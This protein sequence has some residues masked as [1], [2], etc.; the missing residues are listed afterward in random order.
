MTHILITGGAGFIGGHLARLAL[1]AGHQVRLLDNLSPQIHGPDAQFVAPAGAEF[2]RGDVNCRADVEQAIEGVGCVI[3]LAAETGTGQSMY[4]IERYYQVNVQGTALLLDVLANRSTSVRNIVLA[5]SRS[6]YG[7][8]AYLCHACDHAGKRC[9]PGAREADQLAAHNWNPKCPDCGAIIEPTAT[10]ETDQL[11]PASIYA[12]TKLAQEE[13]MRVATRSLGI[14]HSILRFQNV[15]GEGQS[16]KNP[17]TGI[18]S[19]F[20]TRLRLGLSLPIFEDGEESRDFIHV[21]DVAR[22]VLNCIERPHRDG[23]TLN[24]GSGKPTSIMAVAQ[25]LAKA[26]GSDLE[27]EV[28]GQY[29]IGDI[30]HNYADLAA[31][32]RATGNEPSISLEKGLARFCAWVGTQPIPEDMLA[33]AN[34]ELAARKLMG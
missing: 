7:E 5:S 10:R 3:H 29:R 28:T 6:V 30:R 8:G 21:E 32:R 26:M 17:Y 14:P 13:M 1:E 25:A 22:T 15:F 18:L 12:A 31:V 16:L 23:L 33:K 11:S 9:F 20:S 34:A 19:I 27:L 24:V 4:E 2:Q